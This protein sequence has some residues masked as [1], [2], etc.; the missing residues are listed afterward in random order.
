M[1]KIFVPLLA[2]VCLLAA[3]PASAELKSGFVNSQRILNEA[4]QAAKAKKEIEK[5]F[6]KRDQDLQKLAKQLQ[7]MQES[8]QKNS[9]T[10]SDSERLDKERQLNELNRDFQ[11]KQREFREDLNLRQNEEMAAIF[12]KVNKVIKNIAVTEKYD[13]I[14]QEA[15]YASPRID[16]TDRVIKALSDGTKSD[17]TK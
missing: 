6:A 11:R 2:A 13:L 5:E 4:P 10:M 8:M 16:L 3:A 14:L 17:G 1:N 7:T 12:D 15:V 9:V